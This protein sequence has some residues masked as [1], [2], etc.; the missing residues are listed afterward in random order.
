MIFSSCNIEQKHDT[1]QWIFILHAR[2]KLFEV[3]HKPSINWANHSLD[4]WQ[5]QIFNICKV[6]NKNVTYKLLTHLQVL[7]MVLCYC[8]MK[9]I[10]KHFFPLLNLGKQQ[11]IL[12]V[13]ITWKGNSVLSKANDMQH[14]TCLLSSIPI[15]FIYV[16]PSSSHVRS[17][18]IG[19]W[20]IVY[21][22]FITHSVL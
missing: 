9:S 8:E 13:K 21:T 14:V 22:R 7:L 20:W 4:L 3:V 11:S 1:N 17:H 10:S 12:L 6:W 18:P 16:E 5:W 2:E 19:T 15:T